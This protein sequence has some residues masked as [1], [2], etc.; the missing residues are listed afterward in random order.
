V[1][2]GILAIDVSHQVFN[3]VADCRQEYTVAAD[4]PVDDIVKWFLVL[5]WELFQ[6]FL[7]G[8]PR[9]NHL[10]Q[11]TAKLTDA[12]IVLISDREDW[13]GDVVV[14]ALSVFG[15]A[16]VKRAR[17]Q[18]LL[19]LRE[20]ANDTLVVGDYGVDLLLSLRRLA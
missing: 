7:V 15:D 13:L 4:L 10:Y 17:D 5:D 16:L 14:V 8:E 1:W 3:R 18:Q 6:D 12:Y 9:V 19:H 2:P 20:Q 11:L